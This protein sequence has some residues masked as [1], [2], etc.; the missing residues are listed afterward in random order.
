MNAWLPAFAPYLERDDLRVPLAT[1]VTL[2][3]GT[4]VTEVPG[5]FLRL[6][7]WTGEPFTDDFGKKAAGMVELEGEHLFA[8]LA[9]LRLLERDGWSGRWVSSYSAGAEVWKYLTE[10]RDLPRQEQRNRPIEEAEPRQFLAQVAGM[11]KPARY[12]GCWDLFAWRDSSF[13]F[14]QTKRMPRPGRDSV[15]PP[16]VE[17]LRAALYLGDPRLKLTSFCVVHWDYRA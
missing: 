3:V 4:I 1:P 16:Q 8:E 7:R 9:V 17:W 11:N 6:P 15:K 13:A 14:L 2:P 10:W 5:V 12:S